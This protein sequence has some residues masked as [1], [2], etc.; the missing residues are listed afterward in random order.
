MYF[1]NKPPILQSLIEFINKYCKYVSISPNSMIAVNNYHTGIKIHIKCLP[2]T[3]T[4]FTIKT[5]ELLN[6]EGNF[7]INENIEYNRTVVRGVEYK[8]KKII[9]LYDEIFPDKIENPLMEIK[10]NKNI[11]KLFK[12]DIIK[13]KD[14]IIIDDVI[15]IDYNGLDVDLKCNL[16]FVLKGKDLSFLNEFDEVILCIFDGYCIFYNFIDEYTIAVR[17]MNRTL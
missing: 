11:I 2:F 5:K 14:K 3:N 6:L 17:V 1:I 4:K 8:I 10:L 16:N 15:F 12:G 9:K 13:F 7:E